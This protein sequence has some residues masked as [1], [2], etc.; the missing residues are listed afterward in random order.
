MRARMRGDS[1]NP[2]SPYY[3][4]VLY[5]RIPDS[6]KGEIIF[7]FGFEVLDLHKIKNEK[8]MIIRK[9]GENPN[10]STPWSKSERKTLKGMV[11][12]GKSLK[13][14]SESLG[15]SVGAIGYQKSV[16]G[17]SEKRVK[18]SK[19]VKVKTKSG[20]VHIPVSTTRDNAKEMARVAR[21]IAREN[22]KRITMAMFFVE[23]L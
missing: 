20:E 22:G 12:E 5:Y 14:I 9:E 17:L 13:E 19:S 10:G 11:K 21:G 7:L 6:E 3:I 4:S 2:W 16:M 1:G 23:D 18:K 8:I 15:R